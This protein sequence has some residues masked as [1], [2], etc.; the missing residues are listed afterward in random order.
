MAQR[1]MTTTVPAYV[2]RTQLGSLLRQVTQR[3]ARF[4]ITKSGK[5]TA[6]LLSAADFDDMLEELDPEFQKSL[7]AAAKEYRAG[8]AI[9][10]QDYL[11]RRLAAR[12]AG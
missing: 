4:V 8:R 3:K 11:K 10:L 5:P 7:K 2:A 12:R 1:S 6:V 9:S